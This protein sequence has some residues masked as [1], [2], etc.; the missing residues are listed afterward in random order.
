MRLPRPEIGPERRL[1][2]AIVRLAWED[3][4]SRAQAQDPA[5]AAECHKR[6]QQ[7][8][9]WILHDGDFVYWCE[10]SAMNAQAV[11]ARFLMELER[12]QI[13]FESSRSS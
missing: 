5:K 6:R 4:F 1:A 8:I 3:T 9:Q 12:Y 2:A 11:R 13:W 10:M 7:A